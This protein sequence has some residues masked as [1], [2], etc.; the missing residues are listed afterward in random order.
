MKLSKNWDE[1]CYPFIHETSYLCDFEVE[2]DTLCGLVGF[3]IAALPEGMQDMAEDLKQLQPLAWHINGSIR[4]RLAVQAHDQ[5][6]LLERLHHYRQEVG[7]REQL[8]VLPRGGMAVGILHQA[9]SSAKKAIRCMVRVEQAGIEVPDILPRMCN[10]LCNLFFLMALAI[11]Q[12]Q[13]FKETGFVSQSYGRAKPQS[14][15]KP[16]P[17]NE[18]KVEAGST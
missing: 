10:T 4:G 18:A 3:A 2:T 1:V 11:N 17:E 5:Q 13:Q 12:R 14:E 8:F 16:K 15:P 7:E 6:W 9:R